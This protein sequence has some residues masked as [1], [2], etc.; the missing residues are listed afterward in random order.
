[1][2]RSMDTSVLYITGFNVVGYFIYVEC[3][4]QRFGPPAA[5]TSVGGNI[6]FDVKE[7]HMGRNVKH[8]ELN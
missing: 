2:S 5:I 6:C 8:Q 3:W 7:C 4:R 1:M